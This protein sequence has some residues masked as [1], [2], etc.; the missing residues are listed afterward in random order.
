[1]DIPERRGAPLYPLYSMR[2]PCLHKGLICWRG[3]AFSPAHRRC[4]QLSA[5]MGPPRPRKRCRGSSTGGRRPSQ[6]VRSQHDS[7]SDRHAVMYASTRRHAY[8]T[9]LVRGL[10]DSSCVKYSSS[11]HDVEPA[12][13]DQLLRAC[14]LRC[15]GAGHLPISALDALSALCRRLSFAAD[16][17]NITRL[18]TFERRRRH[19]HQALAA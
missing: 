2:T 8:M 6:H 14:S 4:S 1:M 19:T 17:T 9:G 13:L 12:Q 10:R 7:R 16:E 11:F 18:T 15:H 3:P 5:A